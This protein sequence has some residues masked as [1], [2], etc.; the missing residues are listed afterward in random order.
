M[1]DLSPLGGGPALRHPA[2]AVPVLLLQGWLGSGPGHWQRHWMALRPHWQVVDFGSWEQPDPAGWRQALAAAIAACQGPPLLI[3][4]S[5]GCLAAAA[6]IASPEAPAIAGALLV[7]PPDPGRSD[8]PAPLRAFA[9]VARTRF[10]VPGRVLLS[11]DDPYASEAFGLELAAAWGLAPLRLGALGHVNADSGLGAWPE[12]LALAE[13][14]LTQLA[15]GATAP[16][17]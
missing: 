1:S 16:P 2:Q 17:A 7:A 11:S 14:L 12:G 6:L 9:P 15:A 10:A 5:L 3:A 8:T 13:A 4:H